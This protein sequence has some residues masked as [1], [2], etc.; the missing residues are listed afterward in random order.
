MPHAS[1]TTPCGFFLD[2][3][4]HQYRMNRAVRLEKT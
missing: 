1:V 2:S 4:P 3:N